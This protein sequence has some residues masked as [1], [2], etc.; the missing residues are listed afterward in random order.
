MLAT[1]LFDFL[2]YFSGMEDIMPEVAKASWPMLQNLN[3]NVNL[4]TE[5]LLAMANASWPLL[6]SLDLSRNDLNG[7]LSALK[8]ADW[9]LLQVL[10]L[11]ACRLKCE[12]CRDLAALRLP[13]LRQ[14]YLHDN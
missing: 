1:F 13:S 7:K 3:A 2:Y 12:D 5:G 4:T 8:G 6:L 9:P 11:Q 14:L 10:Y